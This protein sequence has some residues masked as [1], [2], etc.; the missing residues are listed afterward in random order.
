MDIPAL[1]GAYVRREPQG[2]SEEAESELHRMLRED[3]ED[4]WD[5][6]I[7]A[8]DAA[9]SVDDLGF[10]GAGPIE[11]MLRF[12]GGRFND[13]LIAR[14]RV[15]PRWGYAAR[16]LQGARPTEPSRGQV[17]PHC[18]LGTPSR[19]S[20]TRI[21]S[22]PGNQVVIESP[23]PEPEH[24]LNGSCADESEV[25]DATRRVDRCDYEVPRILGIF[26]EHAMEFALGF[27]AV[28]LRFASDVRSSKCR[29]VHQ[30]LLIGL[31][32]GRSLS[33]Y[34]GQLTGTLLRP[35]SANVPRL[36]DA[37]GVWRF[38]TPTGRSVADYAGRSLTSVKPGPQQAGR[39]H[40]RIALAKPS[41]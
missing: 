6:I 16:M 23:S 17:P 38:V 33:A 28:S 30:C 31:G 14:A 5:F 27:F 26:S 36:R 25:V 41:H 18:C 11:D 29:N 9:R 21:N 20:P 37:T 7:A 32:D 22:C 13:D 2:D 15:D 1:A 40:C 4:A 34:R 12:W 19:I 39:L 8:I 24:V 3:P 35:A 10:I